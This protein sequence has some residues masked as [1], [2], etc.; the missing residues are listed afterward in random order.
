MELSS[1]QFDRF[2]L[3]L[4]QTYTWPTQYVFKFIIKESELALAQQ[5]FQEEEL[6]LKGS[7]TGK[8]VSISITKD[9][10]SSDDVILMYKRAVLIPGVMG[11]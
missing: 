2:K 9:V 1:I 8:Y 11:L 7:A 6:V 3:L 4:D 5:V 10:H